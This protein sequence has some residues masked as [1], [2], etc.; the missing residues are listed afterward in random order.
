MIANLASKSKKSSEN[1]NLILK[2]VEITNPLANG[3]GAIHASF[4]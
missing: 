2:K 1:I 4:F 3:G